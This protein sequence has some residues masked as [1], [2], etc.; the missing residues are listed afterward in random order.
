M[1][2]NRFLAVFL[3]LILFLFLQGCADHSAGNEAGPEAGNDTRNPVLIDVRTDEE[4]QAGHADTA[5]HIP[6]E[7]IAD[8]INAL[9]LAPD[10]PIYLYCHSGRR[11]GIAL[12]T[13]SDLGYTRLTNLGS[14]ENAQQW[15][16][17]SAPQTP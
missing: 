8:R 6:Y 5:I 4:F 7:E 3:S 17:A 10:Q 14:L 16:Q 12:D 1:I 9:Q 15:L 2:A 11:A 13:L